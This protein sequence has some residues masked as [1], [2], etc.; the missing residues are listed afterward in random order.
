MLSILLFLKRAG[1]CWRRPFGNSH[2]M[3]RYRRWTQIGFSIRH[4]DR[5]LPNNV[6]RIDLVMKNFPLDKTRPHSPRMA[7]MGDAQIASNF[8]FRRQDMTHIHR[9]PT[10]VYFQPAC[11]GR[12]CAVYEETES[13]TELNDQNKS[14]RR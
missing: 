13:P 5:F 14:N 10:T 6:V 4:K 11:R 2:Y 12:W 1:H 8:K 7:R 3:R 9:Y